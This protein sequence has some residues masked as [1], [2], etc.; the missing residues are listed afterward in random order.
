MPRSY[1]AS[2]M[3]SVLCSQCVGTTQ[4]RI[5]LFVLIHSEVISSLLACSTSYILRSWF[6]SPSD[7]VCC[8]SYRTRIRRAEYAFP[9]TLALGFSVNRGV[10]A[11][12]ALRTRERLLGSAR[13]APNRR[14]GDPMHRCYCHYLPA[15]VHKMDPSIIAQQSD[16]RCKRGRLCIILIAPA[17]HT[18]KGLAKAFVS[19]AGGKGP[20]LFIP[21]FHSGPLIVSPEPVFV[22]G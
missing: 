17:A 13:L 5:Y 4:D 8:W 10:Y 15:V 2:G 22:V 7:K 11:H 16:V 3:A 12:R 14:R 1:Q 19:S 20:E 6:A 9:R 18:S 21:P